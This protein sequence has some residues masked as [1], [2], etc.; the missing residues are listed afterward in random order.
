MTAPATASR[1]PKSEAG[2]EPRSP[3]A[4]TA[5]PTIASGIAI[6][7]ASG[8]CSWRKTRD[9]T[10]A[11]SGAVFTSSTEAATEV[12]ERLAIQVAKWSASATPEATSSRRVRGV[13]AGNERRVSPQAKGAR[14]SAAIAMR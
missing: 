14:T 10:T 6:L 4:I 7:T 5:A 11:K 13:T 3:N 9:I 1:L 12:C 8:G 2:E